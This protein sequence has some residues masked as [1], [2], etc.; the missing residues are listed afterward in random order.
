MFEKF[1]RSDTNGYRVRIE[2]V[3]KERVIERELA[4]I[5]I[6]ARVLRW[7]VHIERIDE[8]HVA[9]TIEGF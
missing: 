5:W 7:F 4:S 2:S 6:R 3:C 8:Y 1:V 9:R